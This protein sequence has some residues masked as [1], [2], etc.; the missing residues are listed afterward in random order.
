MKLQYLLCALESSTLSNSQQTRHL[1]QWHL[2]LKLWPLICVEIY[3]FDQAIQIECKF[4]ALEKF[5]WLSKY[6]KIFCGWT[7]AGIFHYFLEEKKLIYG[8]IRVNFLLLKSKNIRTTVGWFKRNYPF[9]LREFPVSLSVP[10]AIV[11]K[12]MFIKQTDKQFFLLFKINT[13]LQT[14]NRYYKFILFSFK[15]SYW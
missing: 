3:L 10:L 14:I 9:F 13:F 7:T 1:K 2:W 11:L 5:K 8:K 4:F 12:S 6:R 15:I